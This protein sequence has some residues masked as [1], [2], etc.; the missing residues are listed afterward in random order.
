MR[1]LLRMTMIGLLAGIACAAH[2]ASS[3]QVEVLDPA[4]G[5]PPLPQLPHTSDAWR[6]QPAQLRWDVGSH[7]W[8]IRLTDPQATDDPEPWVLSL[9]ETYDTVVTFYLP[10]AGSARV[11]SLYD[12]ALQQPGSRLRLTL[13]LAP[14]QRA[15]WIYVHLDRGRQQPISLQ[16]MPQSVYLAADLDRVR[17]L[18]S[19]LS[20]M[21][22]LAL[23]TAVIAFAL[24]RKMLMLLSLWI[25]CSAVYHLGMSGEVGSLLPGLSRWVTPILLAAVS[26]HIG[27]LA[28]H[29]FVY[30]FLALPRHFPRAARVYRGLLWCAA[31]LIVPSFV[32][33]LAPLF[34]STLNLLLLILSVMVL[35][36]SARR[37]YLGD[38]Q[39]WFFLIG[40]G[41]VTVV[42]VLRAAFFLIHAG[43]PGW[44]ELLHP[45][46]DT[47]G[48]L[49]LVVAVARAARY[50]E[51]E[52]RYARQHARTDPLTGLANR[53]ELNTA[54][55]TCLAATSREHQPLSVLFLD[56]DHFKS[57]NDR[58]G[59]AIGDLCLIETA[60]ILRQHV[61]EHDL[62]ARYG[63]EEFVLLLVGTDARTAFAIADTLRTAVQRHGHTIHGH[64]VDL[65]VSVGIAEHVPG[66]SADALLQ[67]ADA[68]LY[69][70]KAEGRNRCVLAQAPA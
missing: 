51:R 63:G 49:V 41:A 54:L 70:A 31:L 2:G 15:D 25:L 16:A 62:L 32:S 22:A 48:A 35:T 18:Y 8:R 47:S 65:T 10:P 21:I 57:I 68:A 24:E 44:L 43:T 12:P 33:G 34:A 59:H 69:R 55:P 19:L 30:F 9:R 39:G 5:D 42:T 4:W 52:M 3:L 66:E 56:L 1:W 50:V 27:L 38:P 20:A 40:W 26:A 17:L 13:A 61:R 53:A 45:I 36:L 7:W 11:L 37:A 23:L 29:L 28:A 14:A 64:P 60:H 67:R 6:A 58:L 46:A